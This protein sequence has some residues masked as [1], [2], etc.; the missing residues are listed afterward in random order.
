MST[1]NI[2]KLKKEFFYKNISV[3]HHNRKYTRGEIVQSIVQLCKHGETISEY[4]TA[5][6][7]D[8]IYRRLK[9]GINEL[10]K[11]YEEVSFPI[12]EHY[13][14]RYR[15]ERWEI[16]IDPTDELFYGKKGDEY[17]IGTEDGN[18]CFRFIEVIVCCRRIRLPVA[19]FPLKKGDSKVEILKPVIEKILKVVNPFNLLAD[20]GFGSGEFI[21]MVQSLRLPFVIR[22][23]AIGDIKR[24]IEAGMT[25]EVH[26]Y[27]LESKER[28]YFHAKFGMSENGNCWALATSH[29]KT[30]S[31]HLWDWYS[32]R[33]EIENSFKTQDRIQFK[34][35]SRYC[36]MRLFAQMVTALFYLIWNIWR[37]ISKV[38]FTIKQFVR[39]IIC[40]LWF[41]SREEID[42][43]QATYLL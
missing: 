31:N 26:F 13:A 2:D 27:E 14:K 25:N 43:L 21:K 33:W 30:H 22:I 23:K 5:P 37:L 3:G 28:V 9:L 15:R 17:V 19:I 29:Y 36:K 18:K 40:K 12:L 8:T 20:A 10:I 4:C 42:K 1:I 34:T 7:S 39:L 6:S 35:A 16:I 11:L 38:Y 41:G 24:Y 32:R